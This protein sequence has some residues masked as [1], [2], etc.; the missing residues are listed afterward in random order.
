VFSIKVNVV[1]KYKMSAYSM[2]VNSAGHPRKERLGVQWISLVGLIT[3]RVWWRAV[4]FSF[5]IAWPGLKITAS[6]WPAKFLIWPVK[7]VWCC[8]VI[9]S[10]RP[11][12][13]NYCRTSD[14]VRLNLS[15]V[16]AKVIL[17]GHWSDHKKKLSHTFF[18]CDKIRLQIHSI[19]ILQ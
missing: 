3:V 18:C 15:N 9:D 10:D 2:T 5:R 16:R 13:A 1:L 11:R 8:M 19:C 12:A 7:F 14:N 17:I 4:T 6:Q